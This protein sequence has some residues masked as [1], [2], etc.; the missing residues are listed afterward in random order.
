MGGGRSSAAPTVKSVSHRDTCARQCLLV[1][2]RS[3]HGAP[4]RGSHLIE[5]ECAGTLRMH[6]PRARAFSPPSRGCA[7][8]RYRTKY[9]GN[10]ARTGL[11]R[12]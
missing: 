11:N 7:W 3:L 8:P 2:I 10:T 6:F 5:G 4:N 9:A 1:Q 12:L